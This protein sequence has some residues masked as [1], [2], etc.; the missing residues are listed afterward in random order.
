MEHQ[1]FT[2]PGQ[3]SHLPLTNWPA[4][5]VWVFIAQM[6]EHCSPNAEAMSSNPVEVLNLFVC[7]FFFGGGG[8]ICNCLKIAITTATIISLFKNVSFHSSHHLHVSF[9]SGVKM[10]ST[11]WSAPILC[12]G[13]NSS[14]LML[15]CCSCNPE[16]MGSNPVE[17]PP[18]FFGGGGICNCLN[19]NYH[20]DDRH[21]K[22]C[23]SAVQIIF[24][25]QNKSVTEK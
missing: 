9:L 1:V 20:C 5:N 25:L 24:M 15:E 18:F 17:A 22:I 4:P 2:P 3:S 19:C 7:L 13:L 23:I 11:N 6:V 14:K 10:N 8:C 21:L 16:A 12:T